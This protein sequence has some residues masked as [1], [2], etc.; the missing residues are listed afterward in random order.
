M[1]HLALGYLSGKI[2]SRLL[3]TELNIPLAL[4]LSVIPDIDLLIPFIEHRGPTHSIITS[5]IIFAPVFAVYHK[6]VTPYFIALIQHFI[7]GDYIAGGGIQ[8]FWPLTPQQYGTGLSIKS[9]TNITLEWILFLT[10]MIMMF[11]AKETA[12]LFQ[13]NN[14]NLTLIIPTFTVLL[15]TFLSFPLEAPAPLVPPHLVYMTIFFASIII[16]L[17]KTSSAHSEKMK[18]Q[19]AKKH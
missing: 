7:I 19:N 16:D 17:H 13:P 6:K 3:K 5:F 14:S 9:Q 18:L 8:L 4:M 1:G 10:S 11:K 2:S 12:K 15:P